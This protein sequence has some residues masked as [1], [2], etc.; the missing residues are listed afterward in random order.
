M[1]TE[2]AAPAVRTVSK[3]EVAVALGVSTRTIERRLKARTFPLRPLGIGD[4]VRF[5][6]ADLERLIAGQHGRLR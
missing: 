1:V 4:H 3:R 2:P 6:R 5:S